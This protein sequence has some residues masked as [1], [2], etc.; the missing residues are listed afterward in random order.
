MYFSGYVK[1][2][3]DSSPLPDGGIPMFDGG[4]MIQW[5]ICGYEKGKAL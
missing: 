2:Y 5:W 3:F 4:P 1:N